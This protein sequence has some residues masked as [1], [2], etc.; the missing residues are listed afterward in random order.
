MFLTPLTAPPA[1]PRVPSESSFLTVSAACFAWS[2]AL[3]AAWTACSGILSDM[4]VG[5]LRVWERGIGENVLM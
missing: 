2:T 3:S 4:F 1:P 5:C